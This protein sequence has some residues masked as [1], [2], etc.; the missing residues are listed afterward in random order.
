MHVCAQQAQG[1]VQSPG[2]RMLVGWPA[3]E[4]VVLLQD[5]Q[6]TQLM[7]GT[8]RGDKHNSCVTQRGQPTQLVS[9]TESAHRT[10][11]LLPPQAPDST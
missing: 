4:D 8:E 6:Q 11:R 3:E 7:R 5:L 10:L 9:D 2:V 1:V